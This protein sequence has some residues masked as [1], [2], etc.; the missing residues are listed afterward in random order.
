MQIGCVMIESAVVMAPM[1]GVSDYPFRKI[2]RELSSALLFTEMIN[3]RALSMDEGSDSSNAFIGPN[4]SPIVAQILG[5]DPG[6]MGEAARR[7][8][9]MGADIVDINM[10]CPVPKVVKKGEGAALMRDP[11]KARRIVQA[12]SGAAG[13]PVTVKIRAGWSQAET[14]A[15]Y[16]APLLVD[17]GARAIT[18]HARTR[19]AMYSGTADWSLIR[20][21]KK[22]V[23]VPVIGNGDVKE[24][25]DGARMMDTTGCDGVMVGRAVLGD[26][27]ILGQIQQALSGWSPVF[28]S[29][30]ERLRVVLAHM[31]EVRK[32]KGERVALLE[33]RKHTAWYIKGLPGASRFRARL[34]LAGSLEHMKEILIECFGG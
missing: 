4:E 5:S 23:S 33:M 31:E 8:A 9:D 12:V 3:A 7:V 29:T 19:E 25:S 28:P 22:I 14:N 18:L 10:G 34:H 21:L 32:C 27:W 1:A 26:P 2:C 30:N 17:A 6:L 15:E 24:P 16:L 13:V 11:L 20:R